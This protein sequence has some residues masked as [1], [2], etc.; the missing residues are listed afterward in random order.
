MKNAAACQSDTND[1]YYDDPSAPK[2]IEL[3]PNACTTVKASTT[4]AISVDYGCA[5]VIA[6]MAK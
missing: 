1:W 2:H 4:G 3:C 6:P 5:T